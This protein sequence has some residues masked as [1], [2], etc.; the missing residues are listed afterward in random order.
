MLSLSNLNI[1]F[2]DRVL[3]D[4]VTFTITRGDRIGLIGRNGAGKSTL[5]KII[6]RESEPDSGTVSTSKGFSVG[7]LPQEALIDTEL[8]VI[9]ETKSAKKEIGKIEEQINN[10]EKEIS[11]RT[12]YESE[13]YLDQLTLLS[14][15]NTKFDLLGGN[16][17]EAD[18]NRILTGLGFE[19]RDLKRSVQELSGGWQMRIELAKIL[20]SR[21]DCILM[22]E[23]TNHLD[24]ESIL[25]LEDFLKTYEGSVLIVS[26]DKR[27]LDNVTNRTIEISLGKTYDFKLPYSK[28]VIQ[29]QELLKIQI[30][31]KKNQDKQIAHMKNFVDKFRAKARQASRAQSKLKA[32]DRIDKIEVEGLDTSRVAFHFPEAPRSG[33]LVAEAENLSKHYGEKFV[34]DNIDFAIERG[35]KLA[36]IGKNGEGKSTFSRI[37]AGTEKYE[38][39]LHVGQN[40]S[41][42]YFSQDAAKKMRGQETVFDVIERQAKG[43]LRSQIRNL[44]GAFLFSGD[45]VYK[46]IDVL[47]GGEKS[48]LALCGMLLRPVNLLIMD[49]PTNHLDIA[50][51]D[52]LKNALAE[53]NG[54]LIIVSHDREFLEGLTNKTIEFSGRKIKEYLGDINDY[55]KSRAFSSVSDLEKNN[56][57]KFSEVKIKVNHNK[58]RDFQREERKLKRIIEKNEEEISEIENNIL[59]I[60]NLFSKPDFHLDHKKMN[61]TQSE[62]EKQKE[63]L[64][65]K[66]NEWE[67]NSNKLESLKII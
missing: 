45:D 20:L 57:P 15:I 24:I 32:I 35:E 47:S 62:Y 16:S 56:K 39:N 31:A 25:W 6:A 52:V 29:R 61:E 63:N 40:V 18:A 21:P 58:N 60:E 26:H 22:D 12:D 28:F 67:E 41:I 34:L 53:F 1:E 64:E 51:K 17:L 49:E 14:D 27:F 9:D 36:F 4:D 46:K 10:L 2:G 50:A 30:A 66:M 55:L 11:R 59:E 54:A 3:F 48:R 65:K 33:R 13:D 44:L 7:Y 8:S 38:G 23:P 42:G 19:T 5:L 37:I 43:D